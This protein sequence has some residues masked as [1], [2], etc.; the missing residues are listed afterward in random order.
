MA[1]APPSLAGSLAQFEPVDLT[2]HVG[3]AFQDSQVQLSALLKAPNSDE[4]IADLARL[5]SHRG[6]VFFMKQDITLPEQKIL[7]LK[8]GQLTGRP[9]SSGLHKHPI[10]EDTPELGADT[11]VISNEGYE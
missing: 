6:V 4:L 1:P 9:E 10:S 5:V 7:G 11:S 3:T 8:L 2:A